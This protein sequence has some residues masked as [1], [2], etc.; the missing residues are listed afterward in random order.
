[1]NVHTCSLAVSS[2]KVC[3]A[4][5]DSTNRGKAVDWNN[6]LQ[7]YFLPDENSNKAQ[8]MG[9]LAVPKVAISAY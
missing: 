9:R 8:L 6:V 1:M 4:G 5:V 7:Q 2:Q 3:F